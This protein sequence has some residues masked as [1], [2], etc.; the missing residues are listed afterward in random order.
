MRK[1]V[2]L[3][4]LASLV[5]VSGPRVDAFAEPNAQGFFDSTSLI[6]TPVQNTQG[7]RVGEIDAL[8]VSAREGRIGYAVVGVG[9]VLGMGERHVMVPWSEV[10]MSSDSA[11]ANRTIAIVDQS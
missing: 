5:G 1:S 8:L 7:Q 3:I 2:V 9:G 4:V 10:R 6:G 11:R